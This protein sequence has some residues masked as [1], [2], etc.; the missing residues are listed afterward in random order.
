MQCILAES[1][2]VIYRG[3]IEHNENLIFNNSTVAISLSIDRLFSRKESSLD[4]R[5]DL[6][7]SM[8]TSIELYMDT[9]KAS[10][11]GFFAAPVVSSSSL[12][13]DL[14]GGCQFCSEIIAE[15]LF[16]YFYLPRPVILVVLIGLIF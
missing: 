1:A 9:S 14:R 6:Y 10:T 2:R 11:S 13:R 12:F 15:C 7:S 5:T 16:R 4:A 8:N 3:L